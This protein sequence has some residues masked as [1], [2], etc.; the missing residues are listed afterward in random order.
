MD[1]GAL[2]ETLRRF[3]AERGWEPFHTPKNLATALLVEAAELAE[4][5]QWLTPEQSVAVGDDAVLHERVGDELA[6]VLL[7]LAQVADRVGVDVDQAVARKLRRNARKHPPS[8]SVVPAAAPRLAPREVHVLV[9]WENVQPKEADLRALV[10]DASDLW[11]FHGPNQRRVGTHH[12][13]FGD[14]V[15]LVP[16]SRTGKNALDFHLTFYIGYIAARYPNA[17]LVVVSNDQGY[18]PM[19]EHARSLGFD[20]RLVGVER[21]AK[22]GRAAKAPVAAARRTSRARPPKAVA[23]TVTAPPAAAKAA[24]K[25]APVPAAAPR[26]RPRRAASPA[27]PRAPAKKA[28]LAPSPVSAPAARAKRTSTRR[29][30]PPRAAPAAAASIDTGALAGRVA[31]QLAAMPLHKRPTRRASLLRLIGS[32]LAEGTDEAVRVAV[33]EQLLA[34][35]VISFEG[36]GGV[37]YAADAA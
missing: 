17:G 9:D 5:F 7:Y 33:V 13:G 28:A 32:R 21:T 31:V 11:L 27:T 10:G 36:N 8:R 12:P 22:R 20:A 4:I 1:F 16:I 2:Q 18:A 26:K 3:A 6:D 25:T 23:E 37:R 19:L 35:G 29:A 15:T 14:R 24:R 34:G 30:V